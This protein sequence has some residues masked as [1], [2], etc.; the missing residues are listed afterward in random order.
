[1]IYA[2]QAGFTVDVPHA[3]V[4][5]HFV[6]QYMQCFDGGETRRQELLAAYENNAQF[7]FCMEKLDT[8][9]C[10]SRFGDR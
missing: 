3:V 7:T 9:N 10:A 2:I 1:M 4:L 6:T 8:R 5:R